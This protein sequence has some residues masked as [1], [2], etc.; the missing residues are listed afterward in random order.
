MMMTAMVVV[1]GWQ[2]G[3]KKWWR[4]SSSAPDDDGAAHDDDDDDVKRMKEEMEKNYIVEKCLYIHRT[5]WT[6][7]KEN[8][9]AWLSLSLFLSPSVSLK[10]SVK[11]A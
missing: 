11:A 8:D 6:V 10:I 4:T 7:L 5:R 9:I 3:T 2:N 1:V